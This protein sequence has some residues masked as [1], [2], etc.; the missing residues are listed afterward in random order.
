MAGEN[1][2]APRPSPRP[3]AMQRLIRPASRSSAGPASFCLRIP[4]LELPD[5]PLPSRRRPFFQPYHLIIVQD[6]DPTKKINVPEG[7]LLAA[8]LP[9]QPP[10]PCVL[11]GS[12]WATAQL[13]AA[14]FHL[15][16]SLLLLVRMLCI[17]ACHSTC[18]W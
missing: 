17:A 5:R 18:C 7:M 15:P 6:G 8:V 16:L 4:T 14:A 2:G 13:V 9:L 12:H 3:T 1:N 10:L 11:G